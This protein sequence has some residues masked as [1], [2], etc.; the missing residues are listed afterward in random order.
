MKGTW[1][2]LRN[3]DAEAKIVASHI[4]VEVACKVKHLV[5]TGGSGVSN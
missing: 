4:P 3:G 1:W 5:E 2:N